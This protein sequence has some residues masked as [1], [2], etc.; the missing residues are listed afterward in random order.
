MRAHQPDTP[1]RPDCFEAT[2]NDYSFYGDTNSDILLVTY[3]KI[4]GNACRAY[5][6]LKEI[7]INTSILK[8]NKI[9]PIPEKSVKESVKYKKIFFFEEGMATGGI[10]E[11]FYN[12]LSDCGF[13]GSFKLTAIDDIYVKHAK[14]DSLLQKLSL[15]PQGMADTVLSYKR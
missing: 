11:H 6:L 2:K 7:G 15:D 12:K 3:G 14:V 5:E 8:L 9:K 4:F 10:G 13:N 1:Y